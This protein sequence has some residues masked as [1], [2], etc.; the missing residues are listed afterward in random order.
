MVKIMRNIVVGK[1]TL[2]SLTNGM[3]ASPLDLFREYIQNAVDSIDTAI[4]RGI[5]NEK[6]A[7]ISVKVDAIEKRITITDNGTGISSQKVEHILLDIGNS[8][9]D[10]STNRGF[11]GIGRLAGLGYCKQLIFSTSCVGESKKSQV[12]FDAQKLRTK[13]HIR[14]NSEE[15]I[16]DV[17]EAVTECEVMPEKDKKH[18]FTVELIGV[19]TVGNLLEADVVKAYL[20]QNLPLKYKPSFRWGNII[21]K[22][23]AKEGYRIPSYSVVFSDGEKEEQLYKCYDNV[24]VSD[25]VKKYVKNINDVEIVPFFVQNKLGAVLWFAKLEYAGT[26]L[27]DY[28][29][30]IRIRQGNILIGNKNTANQYFREERFNGWLIGELYVVSDDIIPNARRDDFEENNEYNELKEQLIEWSALIT[31]EIRKCS[32]ERSNVSEKKEAIEKAEVEDENKLTIED[33]IFADEDDFI[34]GN[35]D[36][37]TYVAEN[38]L[39][40]R[41]QILLGQKGNNYKYKV[42]NMREDIPHEQ[43]R[44]IEKVLNTIFETYPK[45]KAESLAECI[46]RNYKY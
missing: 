45:K 8:E 14:S 32:L 34:K 19:E 20:V 28:V 12:I 29:K 5:L 25:R 17:I 7:I 26:V 18:F 33:V 1:Y 4:D 42:L 44:I 6:D 41:F 22:K 23:I 35:V 24:I 46:V 38:E 10:R 9:K 40:D 13:M 30:G 27:D 39:F 31:K 37:A 3:Y 16:F 2:E 43:R 15:T 11:R 36:E 21:E